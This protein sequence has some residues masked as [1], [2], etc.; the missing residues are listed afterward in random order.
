MF[1]LGVLV[2]ANLQCAY[3][4]FFFIFINN[5]IFLICLASIVES[6]QVFFLFLYIFF[7]LS[8]IIHILSYSR[9]IHQYYFIFFI[10]HIK[11]YFP[12]LK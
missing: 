5:N 3:I 4:L 1:D 6:L 11:V 10:S 7:A 2:Y 12:M 9:I 8:Y